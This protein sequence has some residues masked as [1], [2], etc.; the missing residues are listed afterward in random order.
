MKPTEILSRE[1]RA[2]ELALDTL[3]RLAAAA[4][5][6]SRIDRNASEELLEFFTAFAD[7]MHHEKEEQVLFPRMI[8]HGLPRNFGPIAVMLNEHDQGRAAVQKLRAVLAGADAG[9]ETAA[10]FAVVA[11]EYVELL[12]DHIAKE[13]DVLFPMGEGMLSDAERESAVAAFAKIEH[14]TLGAGGREARMAAIEQL[15]SRLGVPVGAARPAT[16]TRHACGA[17]PY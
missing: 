1:H 2:I 14:D 13:D 7:R 17:G 15:A 9:G 16:R 8:A 5:Q 4:R 10:R 12:R 11:A 6:S 3:E